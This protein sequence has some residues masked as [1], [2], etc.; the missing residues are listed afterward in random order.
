MQNTLHEQPI[1]QDPQ[2]SLTDELLVYL[3]HACKTAE[4]M[5]DWD[6]DRCKDW[7]YQSK[8]LLRQHDNRLQKLLSQ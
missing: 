5:A 3:H 6:K 1:L 4:V 2:S 8:A 7:Y